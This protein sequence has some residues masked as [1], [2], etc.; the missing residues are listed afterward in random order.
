MRELKYHEKKLL[1]KVDFLNWKQ[2]HDHRETKVMRRYHLQDR[3][4]YHKY[5]KLCG[6]LRSFAHRLSLLPAQD[7]FRS[8]MEG[9]ML[10]KLYDMGVLNTTAKLSDIENKLTV[11]AFC[12]RRLAV[13]VCTLKMAET[14]SAVRIPSRVNLQ[15]LIFPLSRLGCNVCRARAHSRWSRYDHRPSVS[16]H[17]EHGGLRYLGRHEQTQKNSDGVQRRVGRL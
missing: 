14:V 8:K 7:P 17:E 10:S 15:S 16:G 4:D 3:E 1:K 11:A 5:N 13:V 9:Q 2:D 6:Q 12:R